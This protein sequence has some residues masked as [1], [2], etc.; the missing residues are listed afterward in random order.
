[1]IESLVLTMGA[2]SPTLRPLKRTHHYGNALAI[3]L[4][5]VELSAPLQDVQ[6][7]KIEMLVDNTQLEW[8]TVLASFIVDFIR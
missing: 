5:L 6:P 4:F 8:S 1:M 7:I 2:K 3:G